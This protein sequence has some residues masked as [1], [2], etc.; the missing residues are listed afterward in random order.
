MLQTIAIKCITILSNGEEIEK[1]LASRNEAA[2]KSQ[3][4]DGVLGPNTFY[5]LA[6]I[7]KEKNIPFNGVVDKPLL[8]AMINIC[9]K[10]EYDESEIQRQ[11]KDY[12]TD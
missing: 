2:N 9:G 8:D 6:S 7:A 4:M 11:I 10:N 3:A 1:K 12:K 5:V